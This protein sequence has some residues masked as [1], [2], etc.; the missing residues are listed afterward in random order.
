MKIIVL[1][2]LISA[3]SAT[4]NQHVNCMDSTI[5]KVEAIYTTRKKE[6]ISVDSVSYYK[7]HI[8]VSRSTGW[9]KITGGK[10]YIISNILLLITLLFFK[11]K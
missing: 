10:W 6:A 4:Q 7:Q 11:I 3:C 2:I 9:D 8:I 5:T 1:I